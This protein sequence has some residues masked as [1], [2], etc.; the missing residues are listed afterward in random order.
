MPAPRSPQPP[1]GWA[2]GVPGKGLWIEG[3][4]LPSALPLGEGKGAGSPLGAR[5]EGFWEGRT[6]GAGLPAALSLN[7]RALLL[8][9]P[10]QTLLL[11]AA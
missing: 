2:E 5:E 8:Q 1:P 10:V 4:R 3:L 11:E 6:L 9:R 7:P